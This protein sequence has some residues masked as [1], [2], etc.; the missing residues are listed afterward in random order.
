MDEKEI[1]DRITRQ[2]SFIWIKRQVDLETS[3]KLRN[4][5]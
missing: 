5:I 4:W 2:V 1:Y 3:Q